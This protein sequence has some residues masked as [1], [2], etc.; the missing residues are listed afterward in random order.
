[1]SRFFP[2]VSRPAV[3][4]ALLC[5]PVLLAACSSSPRWADPTRWLDDDEGPAPTT[6]NLDQ[7]DY[8]NLGSVP[9][10]PRSISSDQ[11]RS[12][13]SEGLQADRSSVRY[14]DQA[15][16]SADADTP[17]PRAQTA[18]VPKAAPVEPVAAAAPAE[19]PADP[20]QPTIPAPK[21]LAAIVFFEH[22]STDLNQKDW[23]ILQGVAAIHKER[24]GKLRLIG[25]ASSRGGVRAAGAKDPNVVISQKRAISVAKAL[26]RAGV[27]K[28]ALIL[29]AMSDREQARYEVVPPGEAGARRTDIFLEN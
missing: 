3:A 24:G 10:E 12:Q 8:P 11:V 15:L 19:A 23:K 29:E 20:Q 18:A 14:S 28:D 6:R 13:V 2:S 25:H 26:V 17:E 9:S 22:G 21:N 4:A 16:T 1:M 5:L 27:S 7:G